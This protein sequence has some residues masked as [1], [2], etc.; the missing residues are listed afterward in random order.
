MAS[1][2]YDSVP[3]CCGD[4]GCKQQIT[5]TAH[6]ESH[7]L[8]LRVKHSAGRQTRIRLAP[9]WARVLA[10]LLE[11]SAEQVKF[12]PPTTTPP[13]SGSVGRL[14]TEAKQGRSNGKVT[15]RTV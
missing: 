7:D 13:H 2:W 8:V 12:K 4:A 5:I 9:G 10:S 1:V 6:P 11:T 3:C 15:V 14:R